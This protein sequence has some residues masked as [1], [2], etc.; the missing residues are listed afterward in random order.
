MYLG[1]IKNALNHR[2]LRASNHFAARLKERDT[3]YK[4]W[5]MT[6]KELRDFVVDNCNSSSASVHHVQSNDHGILRIKIIFSIEDE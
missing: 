4:F 2:E 6:M 3:Y 5:D 1:Y